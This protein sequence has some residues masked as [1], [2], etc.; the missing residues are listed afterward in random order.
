MYQ[1]KSDC[2]NIVLSAA[3]KRLLKNIEKHP[4]YKCRP[5]KVETLRFFGLVSCDATGEVDAFHAPIVRIG[6]YCVSD[7]YFVYKEYLRDKYRDMTL[8][9]LWLPIVVSIV[10]TLTVNALQ[11]LWPLLS[12]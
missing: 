2:E 7:F 9:S 3:D 12:R 11:W 4:H 6:T 8:Q 10:T 1:Q 5:E